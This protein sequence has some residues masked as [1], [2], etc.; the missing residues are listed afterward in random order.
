MLWSRDRPFVR[1]SLLLRS[2]AGL[3]LVSAS[4]TILYL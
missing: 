2:G 3:S 1:H 4:S